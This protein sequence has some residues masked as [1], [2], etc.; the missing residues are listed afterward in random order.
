MSSEGNEKSKGLFLTD[1]MIRSSGIVTKKDLAFE[2]ETQV[3]KRIVK[4]ASWIITA[5]V[6]TIFGYII[7][8]LW[9][10]NGEVRELK[11][12]F[13][14]PENI[15]QHISGRIELLESKNQSLVDSLQKLQ[16]INLQNE[17]NFQKKLK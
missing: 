14:S 3:T 7:G 2:I 13:S 17:I 5:L 12:K 11:G 8:N 10:L 16:F 1:D 15:I 9:I 4:I 6:F